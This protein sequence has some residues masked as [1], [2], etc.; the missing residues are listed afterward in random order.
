[1]SEISDLD[2]V[3]NALAKL[4]ENR[5]ELED[6]IKQIAKNRHLYNDED[7]FK[8]RSELIKTYL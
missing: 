4:A 1:M 7:V 3:A 8:H 6:L 5:I 2:A